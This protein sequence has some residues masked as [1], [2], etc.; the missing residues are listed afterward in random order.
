MNDQ[1]LRLTSPTFGC[2]PE[3]FLTRGDKVIG[4]ERVIPEAGLVVPSHDSYYKMVDQGRKGLVL[5]GVQVELNPKPSTCR[6]ILGNELSAAFK[7]L[8]KHLATMDGISASFRQVVEVDAKELEGLSEKAKALGCA[9]SRN[10]YDSGAR[11][12]MDGSTNGLRS[13]GGHIHLGLTSST[14]FKE[15]ERLVV[16]MDILVGNTAVLMDRNPLNAKRRTQ[17]GRAGE[18]RLPAHG[19]EYRTLSNFWLRAW[20]LASGMMGMSRLAVNV[21]A[22]TVG[23]PACFKAAEEKLLQMVDVDAVIRAINE[24]DVDLAKRN[25]GVVREYLSAHT[26]GWDK[27]GIHSGNLDQFDFFI[28]KVDEG[29]IEYWFAEEPMKHWTETYEHMTSHAK[30]QQ[31]A[32]CG[33]ESFLSNVVGAEMK[34]GIHQ[35]AGAKKVWQNNNL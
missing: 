12:N 27:T 26:K 21:L 8:K 24:N 33:W 22:N 7:T 23:G 32:Q 25:F 20:P 10:I 34:T 28:S 30:I 4:A 31:G 3:I 1:I 17:Y 5:D 15:R 29:G 19:L 16:L 35:A 14:V 2:D 18:H 13:A 9:P 11:V 6:G